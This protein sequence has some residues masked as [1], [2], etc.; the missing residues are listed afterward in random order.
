MGRDDREEY[1]DYLAM[2]RHQ[3]QG[4]AFKK[5]WSEGGAMTVEEAIAEAGG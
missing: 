3:L 4:A 2:L 5:A 1:E